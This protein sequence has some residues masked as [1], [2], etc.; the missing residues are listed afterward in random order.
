MTYLA[1]DDRYHEMIYRRSGRSGLKLP[2]ISLG[3]WHN[4]G[5]DRP[6]ERQRDIVRRAFDLGITHFDLANNYGPPPGSAEENFG[7]L[8]AGDLKPYRDELVISSKAG[9]LMWPGPYGEWGSRKYLISSLDQ[10]LRRLGL[11]YVDIFYSHRFDPETPLEETMGALDAIVRS[12][13]ALYVGISNYDSEQTERAAEILRDLGTPL[14]INQPSYSMMNRWTESDGLLDTLEGVG[15]GCIAYSP[16]AQGLLTDRYLTGIPADSRVRTS[17]FLNEADLDEETMATVRGLAA[18]AERR[19]QTLAQ[20]A[21][22]WALRDPRM[23][24]LIIG[25]SS[26]AQLE[27]NVAALDNLDLAGE[28]LAEIERLLG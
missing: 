4:F 14:L 24:S 9:Y 16:L 26:V 6:F 22:A 2:V 7:R 18:V 5:P 17:V 27:G 28:D 3:L 10:S 13:K 25:A 8:L 19:G 11:D 23:T 12:G 21:L 1:S 15:A 20:L